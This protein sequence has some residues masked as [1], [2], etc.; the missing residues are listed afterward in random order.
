MANQFLI[1]NTMADMRNLSAM[2][3]ASL[4]GINPTYAGVK[5]LGYYE[6]GDTP[7]PINYFLTNSNSLD[8]GGSIIVI[9]SI[10]LKISKLDL[11]DVRYFG[12]FPKTESNHIKF[13]NCCN[14]VINNG[15]SV[16]INRFNETYNF[17]YTSRVILEK[18]KAQSLSIS[19]N[20]A[21]IKLDQKLI[22]SE[23][24]WKTTQNRENIIFSIGTP[25]KWPINNVDEAFD[26]NLKHEVSIEGLNFDCSVYNAERSE[27]IYNNDLISPIQISAEKIILKSI[28]TNGGIGSC[29]KILGA[30][31]FEASDV[32]VFDYGSRDKKLVNGKT[33]L[34]DSYGDGFHFMG[35]KENAVYSLHD[36]KLHGKLSNSG[37]FSRAG[38]VF[39]FMKS[40]QKESLF[41]IYGGEI[42][43]FAK[44]IH[45][46]LSGIWNINFNNV[47]ISNL[48]TL[49]TQASATSFFHF[50]NCNIELS[51]TD[52]LEAGLNITSINIKFGDGYVIFN[53]GTVIVNPKLNT[54]KHIV[55]GSAESFNNTYFDFKKQNVNFYD[56]AKNVSFNSCIFKNFGS[57]NI[58][59]DSFYGYTQWSNDFY[60]NNCIFQIPD[61]FYIRSTFKNVFFH[62]CISSSKVQSMTSG[63]MTSFNSISNFDIKKDTN[64]QI[65]IPYNGADID[66]NDY[67]PSAI[68][69]NKND[70]K[71]I[72]LGTDLADP[73][74]RGFNNLK[75]IV[76]KEQG[77]VL[78]APYWYPYGDAGYWQF[79][80]EKKGNMG[81]Y[82]INSINAGQTWPVNN[83][84]QKVRG[85]YLYIWQ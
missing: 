10:K 71:A 32:N 61:N 38:I 73:L 3:I 58:K 51:E 33:E 34:G 6:K 60:L 49:S 13:T 5:L 65:Y 39:E 18:D 35:S 62:N 27:T 22:A 7:A 83:I 41:N 76:R 37:T 46:E 26:Y 66:L 11:V 70:F 16:W 78:M 23:T 20:G 31:Y 48:D 44:G 74:G 19:S 68:R 54:I 45:T 55:L 25:A 17:K 36:C 63:N 47:N 43:N 59:F 57:T 30:K 85:L 56:G 79:T 29:Y 40:Y 64:F 67:I 2:E 72:V 53:G 14:Y 8:D 42:K 80:M 1:K 82:D 15:G 84:G 81:S 24:I 50:N 75:E 4:Q 77:Y 69:E 28:N 12:L 9:N 21:I 52:G